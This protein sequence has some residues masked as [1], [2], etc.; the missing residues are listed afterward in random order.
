MI[1]PRIYFVS[2]SRRRLADPSATA[3]IKESARGHWSVE[4]GQIAYRAST[5]LTAEAF[6]ATDGEWAAICAAPRGTWLMPRSA[7]PAIPKT[8][9]RG[10]R[11][12]AHHSGY[13]GILPQPES[14]AHTRLKIDI[15]KAARALG[16][17]A[18]LEVAGSDPDGAE[19]I[20]D[21]L[22]YGDEGRMA[23]EIQLSSQHLR[24]FRA[25]TERYRNSGV[26]CCWI[27]SDL[28]VGARLSKAIAYENMDYYRTNG[29]F[30]ADLEEL[31][32]FGVLLER[33][34]IYPTERPMLRFSRGRHIRRMKMEEAIEGALKGHPQW[35]RPNWH[36]NSPDR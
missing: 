9:I 28:T 29:E 27:V 5:G 8:S 3:Q 7:W 20:A 18:E 35:E 26:R 36:W 31:I 32:L 15:V 12:F 33:K 6:S 25:R 34:D 10:L 22:V 14:Y 11:F 1:L 21:A 16:Y 4:L 17:R 2:T 23:F 19:W 24:D 30:Q 13:T